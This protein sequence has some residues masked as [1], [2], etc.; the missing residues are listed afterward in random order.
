LG[1]ENSAP[2]ILS[3]HFSQFNENARY[4][5]PLNKLTCGMKIIAS[6]SDKNNEQ[7]GKLTVLNVSTSFSNDHGAKVTFSVFNLFCFDNLILHLRLK[8]IQFI[9]QVNVLPF[10][11]YILLFF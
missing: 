3:I 2:E 11:N 7:T 5:H 8:S 4:L 1:T 10:G 6:K 9:I